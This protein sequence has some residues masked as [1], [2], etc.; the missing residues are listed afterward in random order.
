MKCSSKKFCKGVAKIHEYDSHGK[1]LC[2]I[3][4]INIKTG[5]AF[6]HA[7]YRPEAKAAPILLNFCPWCG[8]NHRKQWKKNDGGEGKR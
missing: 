6:L 1:G 4:F 5:K 2:T 7:A 8:F 3:Q